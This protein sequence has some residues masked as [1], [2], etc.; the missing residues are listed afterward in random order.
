MPEELKLIVGLGNPGATYSATRHNVGF[1]YLDEL[2]RRHA[3]NFLYAGRFRAEVCRINNADTDCWL[4]KPQNFV[5]ES[6]FSVRAL[7]GFYRIDPDRILVAHD[8][9]DLDVGVARIKKA[10]GHGGHNGLRDII[11]QLGNSEFIRLRIG[12]GHPGSRENVTPYVLSRPDAGDEN[13]I[14]AAIDTAISHSAEILAGN[15]AKVMT[16][17][18]RKTD[19]R[20]PQIK[21]S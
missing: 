14:R 1:W 13:L 18:N 3:L 19:D 10:G 17:L 4:C 6:G 21:E 16:R 11:R 9:L 8:E 7:A 5:N 20:E 2:A 12:I 15:V